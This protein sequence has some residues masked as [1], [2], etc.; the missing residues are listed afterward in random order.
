ML[1]KVLDSLPTSKRFWTL[2]NLSP[3]LVRIIRGDR[4]RPDWIYLKDSIFVFEIV[5]NMLSR[6]EW[7]CSCDGIGVESG[8]CV[9]LTRQSVT[10]VNWEERGASEPSV[11]ITAIYYLCVF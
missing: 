11:P 6:H 5:F 1:A 8:C 4:S 2:N 3:I 10:L 7:G 9:S